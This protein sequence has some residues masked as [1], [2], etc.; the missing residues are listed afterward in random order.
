LLALD[1]EKVNGTENT[2]TLLFARQDSRKAA[3]ALVDWLK[4]KKGRC[5]RAEMSAF[6]RRLESGELGFRFSRTNFYRGILH[7]FLALGLIAEGFQYDRA[8]GGPVKGYHVVVQPVTRH[9]PVSP[10]LPHLIH[11]LCEKWNL[12][13]ET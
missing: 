6:S 5:N 2:A 11:S 3:Q 9:P 10:S 1:A 4:E 12:E 8:K 13:V 7:R